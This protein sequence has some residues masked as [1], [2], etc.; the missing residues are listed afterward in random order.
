MLAGMY[1]KK[2]TLPVVVHPRSAALSYH[3]RTPVSAPR[4]N[5][6]ATMAILR[7]DQMTDDPETAR[8]R[9]EARFKKKQE[10][11]AGGSV[12]ARVEY[13]AARKATLDRM[14]QLKS[15]R[16]AREAAERNATGKEGRAKRP[17][18]LP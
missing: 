14:A 10:F 4:A 2:A 5:S 17:K 13:E 18:S 3:A 6:S 16:L 1:D 11:A 7:E 8:A 12:N 15:L 9:A